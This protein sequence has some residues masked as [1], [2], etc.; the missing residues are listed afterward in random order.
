MCKICAFSPEKPTNFG[1]N[2]TYLEDPGI[3]YG[4]LHTFG[5]VTDFAEEKPETCCTGMSCW[6]LRINELFHPYNK[7]VVKTSPKSVK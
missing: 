4:N 5:V 7:Q 3:Y 6:Y 1:R 2:C